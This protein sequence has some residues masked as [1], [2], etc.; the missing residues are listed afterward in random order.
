[1]VGLVL[2]IV[3]LEV[4]WW[5]STKS[6][7]E[8]GQKIQ[9]GESELSTMIKWAITFM[10]VVLIGQVVALHRKMLVTKRGIFGGSQKIGLLETDDPFGIAVQ[11]LLLA[12]HPVGFENESL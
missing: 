9:L 11:I 10:T 4:S 1:M 3:E 2:A 5:S 12:I 6:N 8:D 7:S